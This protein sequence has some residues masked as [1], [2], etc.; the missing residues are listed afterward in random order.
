MCNEII[1][2]L[3]TKLEYQGHGWKRQTVAPIRLH[4]DGSWKP[5]RVKFA[6]KWH[7]KN[8]WK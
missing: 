1:L 4:Q 6:R 5:F 8:C 2:V 3:R 7:D